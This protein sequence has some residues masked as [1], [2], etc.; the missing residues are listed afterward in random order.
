MTGL[1]GLGRRVTRRYF[2]NSNIHTGIK[3]KHRV[4]FKPFAFSKPPI[5]TPVVRVRTRRISNK[6]KRK[7]LKNK[8]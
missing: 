6:K 2:M 1:H 5:I 8:V 4:H 7:T 3:L